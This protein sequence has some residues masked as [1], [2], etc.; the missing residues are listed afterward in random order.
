MGVNFRH[1]Q[2][3]E[4]S[5]FVSNQ[6]GHLGE[7][8]AEGL[9]MLAVAIIPTSFANVSFTRTSG[10]VRPLRPSPFPKIVDTAV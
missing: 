5:S 1:P 9:L 8:K 4:H 6:A 7:S 3:A 10:L 2:M